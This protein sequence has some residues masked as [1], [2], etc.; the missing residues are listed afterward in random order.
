MQLY[1]IVYIVELKKLNN[2]HGSQSVLVERQLVKSQTY[3]LRVYC[4]YR[5]Q[6]TSGTSVA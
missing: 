3:R 5:V 6:A 2:R 4:S 1:K